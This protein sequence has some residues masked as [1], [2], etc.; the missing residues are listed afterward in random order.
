[1]TNSKSNRKE[2]NEKKSADSQK[3][4]IKEGYEPVNPIS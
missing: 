2:E 3:Q 1:M 4:K